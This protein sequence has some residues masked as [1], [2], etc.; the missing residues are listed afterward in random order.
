MLSCLNRLYSVLF[1]GL[2]DMQVGV[3]L[4]RVSY[5]LTFRQRLQVVLMISSKTR[6]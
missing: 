5:L 2:I 1:E 6:K 4:L 3:N